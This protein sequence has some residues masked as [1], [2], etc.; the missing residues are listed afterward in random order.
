MIDSPNRVQF[1][2]SRIVDKPLTEEEYDFYT[3]L[4][5]R[6]CERIDAGLEPDQGRE[7]WAGTLRRHI[8]EGKLTREQAAGAVRTQYLLTLWDKE[9]RE[10]MET[11]E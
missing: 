1:I 5:D 6:W 2:N 9:H 4:F 10:L 11:G 7:H 8:R 3:D